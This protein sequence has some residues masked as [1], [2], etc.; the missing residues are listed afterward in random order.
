VSGSSWPRD[1]RGSSV[2]L[3]LGLFLI[4]LLMVAGS[5][6]AG[7]AFVQQDQLQDL[8][9]GAAVAAASAADLD[10]GREPQTSGGWFLLLAAVQSAVND[11]RNRDPT[12]ADVT[13]QA[14]PS[15]DDTQVAVRCSQTRTIAFGSLFGYG[16]GVTHQAT[17]TA[18]GRLND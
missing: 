16:N 3:I 17:S 18:K 8:C 12:R 15:A 10:G 9:D 2:P 4:A 13:M 5:V 7:D 14:S 1:D 6:A 11:Y